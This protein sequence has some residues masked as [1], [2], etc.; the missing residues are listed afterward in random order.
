MYLDIGRGPLILIS[1][2]FRSWTRGG[3]TFMES[4]KILAKGLG[5]LM[6]FE[7]LRH[8]RHLVG[9]DRWDL[10]SRASDLD[11]TERIVRRYTQEDL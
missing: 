11:S 4:C 8:R 9:A 10:A 2:S 5:V 7:V 6:G 1:F 3:H